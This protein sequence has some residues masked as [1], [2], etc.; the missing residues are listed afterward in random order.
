MVHPASGIEFTARH[1]IFN[2]WLVVHFSLGLLTRFLRSNPTAAAAGVRKR[3][4]QDN[5]DAL[6]ELSGM[7]M[8]EDEEENLSSDLL[9]RNPL[10]VSSK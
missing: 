10:M 8:S 7:L 9:T 6:L 2:C 4:R 3:R 1:S 5:E